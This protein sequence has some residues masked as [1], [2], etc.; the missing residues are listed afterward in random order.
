MKKLLSI[1]I[2]ASML[3]STVVLPASAEDNSV[4]VTTEFKTS[5][6]VVNGGFENGLEGWTVSNP[7]NYISVAESFVDDAGA[8]KTVVNGKKALYI[9]SPANPEKQGQSIGI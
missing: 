1:L 5:N 6:L 7:Y 8:T 3:F 9:S 4:N 2:T